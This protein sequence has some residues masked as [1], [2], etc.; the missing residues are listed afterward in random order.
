MPSY[1]ISNSQRSCWEKCKM[2]WLFVF[3]LRLRRSRGKSLDLIIGS[4]WHEMLDV[5]WKEAI[6][7]E[8]SLWAQEYREVLSKGIEEAKKEAGVEFSLDSV[9]PG[10]TEEELDEAEELLTFLIHKYDS[11]FYDQ[12]LEEYELIKSEIRLESRT[13]PRPGRFS[14]VSR[15][16]G[17][18]DK[19]VKDKYGQIWI[20]EHKTCSSYGN[21]DLWLDRHEY[22]PQAITYP[23]L[24]EQ[25][26]GLKP[27]GV[28]YDL[29]RKAS[30]PGPEQYKVVSKGTR[31]SKILPKDSTSTSL[32]RA[33]RH[34][35]F[36]VE[37]YEEQLSKLRR[38]QNPFVR[39]YTVRFVEQD[40]WRVVRELWKVSTEIRQAYHKEL[41]GALQLLDKAD[42]L[43]WAL[44]F[45]KQHGADYPRSNHACYLYN[46]SCEYMDLCKYQNRTAIERY[47]IDRTEQT[48]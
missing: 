37:D 31:L 8:S 33:I 47:T 23:Y 18:I 5:W 26:L 43:D 29:A 40:Q 6:H 2:L 39:R 45:L 21:L 16:C 22:N 27:V 28:I 36:K 3:G 42:S 11:E 10:Y 12:T 1:T 35:G 19:I 30:E 7:K 17:T 32:L 46:R 20:V 13:Q 44:K 9:M 25:C 14:P 4:L 24:V 34:Y 15:I 38:K 48:H 41:F